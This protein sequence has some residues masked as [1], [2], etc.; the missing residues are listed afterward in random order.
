MKSSTFLLACILPLVSACSTP[1]DQ[2]GP[3]SIRINQVGFYPDQEKTL[4]LEQD[5]QCEKIEIYKAGTDEKVWEGSELRSAISPWSGKER[6]IFDF[7]EITEPGKYTVK[8]GKATANFTISQN[9]YDEL[10]KAALTA[11]YHQRSGM[12]LDPEIAGQ[13]ARKGGH[14]DTEVLI[15][16]SAASKSR[17]EGTVISSPKG[18]YDAG[19][20]NKYIVN[21]GYSLGLMAEA[22]LMFS[23]EEDGYE[24]LAE[25][26]KATRKLCEPVFE[27][28]SYN[29]Q[30]MWTMQDPEDG[31]VYHKLTTPN[32]EG[33]VTPTECHQQRYV[34]QKSVTAALDFAG[35]LYS[36]ARL[37]GYA[38]MEEDSEAFKMYKVRY[39]KAA[40]AYA[41]AK[42]HPDAFYNQ[43]Q[44]NYKYDPDITTGAYGD[45]STSDEFFWAASSL[46][47]ASKKAEYL[48]DVKQHF[49]ESFS[50]MSWGY[51]A[52][53]GVFNW[54]QYEKQ[55]HEYSS[56]VTIPPY[57]KDKDE[58][59][60]KSL[61]LT[62]SQE[63]QEIIDRCKEM[64]IEY[65]DA[66]ILA[67]EVSCFNSAYGNKAEDFLWGC[68]SSF[69]DQAICFLY[70]YDI[71]GD[72]KY[73]V[74]AH[75]N[76]NYILGQNATGYCYVTGFGTKSPMFPHSRL[77]H[78]DGI[79][80]PIPG[81]LVGGPNPGQ[82]DIADVK[83]YDSDYPD[84][85]YMDVMPS[86]ASN[87][88]AINWNASL[89]AAVNWL[90]YIQAQQE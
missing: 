61:R 2:A 84:E 18:W 56:H 57:N 27:E 6:R 63:E 44:I 12:D 89:V 23:A 20:Y 65:C 81:L 5:N 75:R 7:S 80:D 39:D 71:T 87:E 82:N 31:G 14:P 10:A 72:D 21:S 53:L 29:E 17:P 36:M 66:A 52:P 37:H 15:H 24:N 50:L 88:I 86:Y 38:T 16:A 35:S 19:D 1:K 69:C 26:Q 73:L 41:W 33:F 67:A 43:W 51:V 54:L 13:W 48:E 76:V 85:S 68:S 83:K 8:A 90:A 47:L 25:Y 22:F 42:A 58:D 11:F 3:E 30:W 49:P 28:L 34:V 4:T 70:A 78:S 79:E 62:I 45:Y 77:C 32:F 60:Y 74:N 59:I 64:L 40:A 55:M 46:Y 9:A